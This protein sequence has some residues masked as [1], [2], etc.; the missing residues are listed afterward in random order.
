ML[1]RAPSITKGGPSAKQTLVAGKLDW[2]TPVQWSAVPADKQTQ[3]IRRLRFWMQWNRDSAIR[4]L[5]E[6]SRKW[7][8]EKKRQASD[9][10]NPQRASFIPDAQPEDVDPGVEDAHAASYGSIVN[11]FLGVLSFCDGC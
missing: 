3:A 5:E 1:I 4:H 8:S 11:S 9:K 6:R 7:I 2:K 10:E